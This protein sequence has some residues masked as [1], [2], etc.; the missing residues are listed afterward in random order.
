MVTF[1]QQWF[2]GW[3]YKITQ[4][5]RN[6]FEYEKREIFSIRNFDNKLTTQKTRIKHI[7]KAIG[8]FK[9]ELNS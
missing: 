8:G 5:G 6:H 3:S 9:K 1:S 2:F 7:I 4:K